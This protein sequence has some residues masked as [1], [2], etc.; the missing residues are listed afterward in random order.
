MIVHV[1]K[2]WF[3]LIKTEFKKK[4]SLKTGKTELW[5]FKRSPTIY[6]YI[7]TYIYKYI[8]SQCQLKLNTKFYTD[9]QSCCQPRKYFLKLSARHGDDAETHTQ[10]IIT[11]F[12]WSVARIEAQP[13]P[14]TMSPISVALVVLRIRRHQSSKNTGKNPSQLARLTL[15]LVVKCC[16]MSSDVS[17][18]ITDKLRP[19]PKHGSRIL[20]VHG[21][22]KAR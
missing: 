9:S 5:G 4:N 1:L 11:V 22:Q 17:W 7:Y 19:M 2:T 18:H 3:I 8:L 10:N 15:P 6:I 13:L 14:V 21:N 12:N 20:Y 16:L